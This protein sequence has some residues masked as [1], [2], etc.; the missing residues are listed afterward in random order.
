MTFTVGAC[1]VRQRKVTMYPSRFSLLL[2]GL[3]FWA[4]LFHSRLAGAQIY[5]WQTPQGTRC[6]SDQAPQSAVPQAFCP[7]VDPQSVRWRP[8]VAPPAVVEVLVTN[9]AVMSR[10]EAAGRRAAVALLHGTAPRLL[11]A[12]ERTG[13]SG[14][15]DLKVIGVWQDG[16]GIKHRGHLGWVP[17][18]VTQRLVTWVGEQP[19][20]ASLVAIVQ[21]TPEESPRIQ[22]DIW[23]PHTSDSA[24]APQAPAARTTE[25]AAEAWL[26]E[27]SAAG[28]VQ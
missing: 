8:V 21:A 15:P 24:P 2:A 1:T 7:V 17:A 22:I 19:L 18:A 12:W 14:V 26:V 11:L 10:P 9:V 23:R 3:G 27:L 20:G 13:R 16:Q 28:S 4:A 6:F 5:E 25:Q